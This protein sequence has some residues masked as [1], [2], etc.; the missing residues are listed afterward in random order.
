MTKNIKVKKIA[1]IA[2]YFGAKSEP[3]AGVY[4]AV[5]NSAGNL[6]INLVIN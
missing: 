1:D 2:A 6:S 3:I 4:F 5:K